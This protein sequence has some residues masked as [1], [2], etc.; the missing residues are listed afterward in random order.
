MRRKTQCVLGLPGIRMQ[1]RVRSGGT[2]CK[3]RMAEPRNKREDTKRSRNYPFYMW[4]PFMMGTW[5]NLF[6]HH[7]RPG[8][9]WWSWDLNVVTSLPA[10][11]AVCQ[12][13]N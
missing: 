7:N 8:Q 9:W 12:Q 1:A 2:G 13:L 10:H 11:K 6:Q 5:K 3:S 4:F